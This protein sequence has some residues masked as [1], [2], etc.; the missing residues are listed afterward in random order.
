MSQIPT[1]TSEC[2]MLRPFALSDAQTVQKLAG[3][4]DVAAMTTTIPYPYEDGMAEAWIETHQNAFDQGEEVIFAITRRSDGQLIGAIGI[5]ID[6]PHQLGEMGYWIG[7]PYWN[8][9][10]CTEAA[11]TVL[12][13][14]FDVLHL[15]R[16]QARHMTKNPTSGRVMQKAGMQYEGTL[17]QSLCRWGT[18]ED[19][20]VYATLRTEFM[21][22]NMST[23]ALT[24]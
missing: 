6:K 18:Y 2:L 15:N 21:E 14:A 12:R 3:E 13:Y 1:L 17:R 22:E 19:A 24:W 23:T 20:A 11:R 16:V 10:Y 9:G 5:S 7:K 8:H 4:R